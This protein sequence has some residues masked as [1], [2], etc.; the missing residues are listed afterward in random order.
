MDRHFRT[1]LTL[2]EIAEKAHFSKYHFHRIFKAE[3]GETVSG[4][5]RRLRLEWAANRLLVESG[6]SIT[7][8]ALDCGF[9]SSQNFAT[10]FKKKYDLSPSSFRQTYSLERWKK[11]QAT[12]RSPVRNTEFPISSV[13]N[14]WINLMDMPSFHV[15]YER[16]VGPYG[17]KSGLAAFEPLLNWAYGK[18]NIEHSVLLGVVW[19]NPDMTPPEQCRYDACITVPEKVH[20]KGNIRLATIKGGPCVVGHCEVQT[21]TELENAYETIFSSWF[22]DNDYIPAD[23]APY[24]IYLNTPETHPRNSMLIDICIPV[25][26]IA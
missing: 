13:N 23:K 2:D 10:A 22:P 25:E 24:E 9:C 3:T 6:D 16:Y 12:D 7:S 21:Y 26:K 1:D 19:D 14:I 4:H 18:Y 11:E 8:I 20:T 5:I 17:E 15:A